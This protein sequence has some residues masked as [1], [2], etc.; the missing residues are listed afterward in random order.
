VTYP[1]F[2]HRFGNRAEAA[3]HLAQ[4]R[5]TSEA[6]RSFVKRPARLDLIKTNVLYRLGRLH[7]V[8]T[9]TKAMTSTTRFKDGVISKGIRSFI[10]EPACKSGLDYNDAD[11]E[12]QV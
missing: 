2:V 4:D 11:V 8:M 3:A 12:A 6:F 10:K 7:V 5:T 9:S 1:P